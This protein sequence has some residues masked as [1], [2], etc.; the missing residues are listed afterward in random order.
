[1][2][3]IIIVT[4][5][6]AEYIKVCLDSVIQN[7]SDTDQVFV[8][9][10]NS[11]DGTKKIVSA[12]I[13]GKENIKLISQNENL[14][15]AKAVNIGLEKSFGDYIFLINPDTAFE[16]GILDKIIYLAKEKSADIAGIRQINDKEKSLGSF[17]NF[18]SVFVNFI[19]KIKLARIFSLGIYTRYNFLTKKLFSL[20]RPVDWVGG[21]FMFVKK[22]VFKKIGKFDENFF[23]YFED[24]DFCQR[25]KKNGSAT[26]FLGS[27]AVRHFGGKSFQKDFQKQKLYNKKSLE[28]FMKKQYKNI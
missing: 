8:V 23:M 15:F 22:E 24:V 4:Y 26:W 19:E 28:Y 21:G 13:I 7:I 27:I 5:N 2:K 18:P 11:L 6:S 25:A 12:V 20:D 9:D 1:M 10:N 16:A 3:S 14:G 17:G